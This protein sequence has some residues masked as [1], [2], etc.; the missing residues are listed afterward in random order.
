MSYLFFY[1]DSFNLTPGAIWSYDIYINIYLH[2]LCQSITIKAESLIPSHDEV[3]SIKE[4]E[5]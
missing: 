3:C 5:E 2:N 4:N 1:I